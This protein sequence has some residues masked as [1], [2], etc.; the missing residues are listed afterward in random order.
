MA[1]SL[2]EKMATRPVFGMTVYT[3]STAVIETMGYWGYDFAFIDAEHTAMG[4]DRD[5]EKLVMAAQISGISPLV[6]VTKVDA[7]EIRKA[8]EMG[9]EGVII[10]H[11][12]DRREAEDCVKW[13]KYPPYGRRGVD[14]SVRATHY[15]AGNF[16][17]DEF[18]TLSNQGLILPMAEDYEFMDNIDEIME[19]P[20]IDG[21]N[22]GPAD[23]AS[24]KCMRTFYKLDE[25]VIQDALKTMIAKA[26][27]KGMHV[28][29]PVVPPNA[30]KLDE[31]VGMGVDMLIL[32]NDIFNQNKMCSTIMNDCVKKYL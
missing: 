8:F 22:F 1:M 29:A 21:I 6:R 32:G 25:P 4:I 16:N 23:F 9:A 11:I 26:K 12:H 27:P 20:G 2:R 31:L 14:G 17:W 30:E 7:I 24:S 3:G 10:P 19:V 28:M 13:S 5:M 18:M 15:G